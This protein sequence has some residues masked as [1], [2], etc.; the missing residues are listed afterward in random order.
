VVALVIAPIC[1][2]SLIACV[3][4]GIVQSGTLGLR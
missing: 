1:L 2:T 3:I 4:G